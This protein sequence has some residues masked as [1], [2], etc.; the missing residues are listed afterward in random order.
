MNR[1]LFLIDQATFHGSNRIREY[2]KK[3]KLKV[4]Q[5][6]LANPE[7]APVELCFNKWK[8]VVRTQ[9]YETLESLQNALL[10][11]AKE[12]NKT[13]IFNFFKHSFSFVKK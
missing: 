13:D 8:T 3:N 10:K 11:G 9:Y 7:F 5:N 12:I 4:I 2:Y 6:A 1:V